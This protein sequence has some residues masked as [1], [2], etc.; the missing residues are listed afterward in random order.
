VRAN[1]GIT[2]S[3]FFIWTVAGSAK[4]P[5]REKLPDLDRCLV[6]NTKKS[7]GMMIHVS[8]YDDDDDDIQARLYTSP[9]LG[10]QRR[11]TVT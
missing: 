4:N 2:G 6:F 3:N 7:K 5:L 10:C 9:S 8:Y 11:S 1:V